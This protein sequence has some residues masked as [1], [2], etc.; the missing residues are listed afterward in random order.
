MPGTPSAPDQVRR[1][2]LSALSPRG[3]AIA[4]AGAVGCLAL[5]AL[6]VAPRDQVLPGAAAAAAEREVVSVDVDPG[7][8]R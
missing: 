7:G 5:A 4:A 8:L 1:S 6:A 2:P 3:R